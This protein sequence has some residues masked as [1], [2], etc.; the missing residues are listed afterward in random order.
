[1][2]L[3]RAPSDIDVAEV[4][5]LFEGRDGVLDCVA[6]PAVCLLEPGC[7]LRRKLMAAEQAFYDSLAGTTLDELIRRPVADRGVARLPTN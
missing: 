1:M 4:V 6:D 3:A 5:G 7:R 2:S